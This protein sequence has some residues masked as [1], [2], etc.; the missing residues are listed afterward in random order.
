MAKRQNAAWFECQAVWVT[1]E[2]SR[3][4]VSQRSAIYFAVELVEM[5]V[6]ITSIVVRMA[7]LLPAIQLGCISS[8]EAVAGDS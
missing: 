4:C 3:V 1:P 5:L 8:A 7:L 2:R 6:V